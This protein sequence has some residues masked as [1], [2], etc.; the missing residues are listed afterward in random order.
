MRDTHRPITHVGYI[1]K[2]YPRLSETFILNEI[3]GLERA[4]VDVS[5]YSLR[6]ATE[7]RFHPAIASVRGSVSYLSELDRAGFLGALTTLPDLRTDRLS[8]VLEFL[9]LI[10]QERR[11]R[12]AF[13]AIEVAGLAQRADL[14]HIHAH[15]LTIASHT[16][17]VVHLLTGIPYSVTAHAKDIYRHTVDWD[18]AGRIAE[19]ASGVVTVCDANLT[20]LRS[21]L[22]GTNTNLRRIYNGLG[23]QDPPGPFDA[24]EDGL[25]IGVGRLVEKKGFDLLLRAVAG[26]AVGHPDV[27]CV[28]IGDGDQRE[29][30]EALAIELGIDDRVTFLGARPQNEVATWLRRATIMA[31]PCR[32]GMDGNQDALPTVLIEALAAGLPAV[33]TPVGGIPEIISDGVEG[34]LVDCDN[35][36]A[37]EAEISSLLADRSRR[38]SMAAAGPHKLASTFQREATIDELIDVFSVRELV[39]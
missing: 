21:R 34:V 27:R 16:A 15:F 13:Q 38:A 33:T 3:L 7:G 4:G 8:Q 14:D 22:A 19:A 6:H 23:P 9:D 2:Q 36:A 35:V 17:H 5:I 30:L 37:L 29:A 1:L 20:H 26:L 31:A 28:L 11:A 10:P 39:S 12:L 24:R 32:I 25:V 18:L